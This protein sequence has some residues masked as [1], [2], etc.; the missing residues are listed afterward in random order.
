MQKHFV[1]LFF[2]INSCCYCQQIRS[3]MQLEKDATNK[4]CKIEQYS[5]IDK[6]VSFALDSMEKL[7]LVNYDYFFNSYC[8]YVRFTK[9]VEKNYIEVH[10]VYARSRFDALVRGD[11]EYFFGYTK[12]HNTVVIFGKSKKKNEPRN[13]CN[14]LFAELMY[15]HLPIEEQHDI[16]I[17]FDYHFV[18]FSKSSIRRFPIDIND[19]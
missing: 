10:R 19:E 15:Y 12:W 3:Y 16:D 8:Y 2:L 18:N 13:C 1:I 5:T 4:Q 14:K 9:I 7:I 6:Q 11:F 17:D